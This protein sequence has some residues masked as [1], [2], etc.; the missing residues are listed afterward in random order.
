VDVLA[1]DRYSGL[2]LWALLILIF[3][4]WVPTTF[5]SITT[6]R[7]VAS[8][9]AV[10]GLLALGV[11]VPLACGEF[12]L[13]VGQV[14]GFTGV[15]CIWLQTNIGLGALLAVIV[16]LACACLVGVFNGFI[17]TRFG[18]NSFIVTLGTSSLLSAG[19]TMVTN[20]QTLGGNVSSGF[21]A[22]GEREIFTIQ[23]P[24]YYLLALA[25]VLWFVMD[26]MP[27][28]RYLLAT[29]GNREAARLSGIRTQR[30]SFG[31]LIF[32]AT[33][34]GFAG[35][36]YLTQVGAASPTFGP[37]YLLPAYAAV[38]LGTTQL[39]PGR[40]NV[41]GTMLAVFVL[42]TG[43]KGL[44]LVSSA[45]W[46]SDFFDGAALLVAVSVAGWRRMKIATS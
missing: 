30:L 10:T 38:F 3:G 28:G 15:L 2:Y 34:A 29:G 31:S 22:A 19:I 44:Q 5:L 33:I 41:W 9:Q 36:V 1:L 46:T 13:S 25:I 45:S 35:I 18:V 16:S 21:L 4:I 7:S 32:S 40:P 20:G 11:M 26:Q 14:M 6:I 37:P 17:V 27:L 12:D 23:L 43:V 24:F 39:K 42:A 8:E